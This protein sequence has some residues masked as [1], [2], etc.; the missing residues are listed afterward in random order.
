[1]P[2]VSTPPPR[3]DRTPLHGDAARVRVRRATPTDL[4]T[5][6]ALEQ[7]AFT[8]DRL[9][10]AQYRR[11]LASASALVLVA[12]DG[13][14]AVLGSALLLFR[15]GSTLARLYSIASAPAARGRGVGATLLAAAE[16]AARERGCRALRLE[17]RVDNGAAIGLYERAGYLRIGR[18]GAY[19]DDGADAWRYEKVL[20]LA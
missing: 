1:V 19:Y 2:R 12:Q 5:L 3:S 4:T 6:L 14:G 11:H 7:S 10:R 16:A 9:S 8:G 18:Y 13:A 15:R 17:V 20:A